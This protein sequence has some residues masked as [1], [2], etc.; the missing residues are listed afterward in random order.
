M[1]SI[2]TAKAL[3]SKTA[4]AG[5]DWFYDFRE[6]PHFLDEDKCKKASAKLSGRYSKITKA[7]DKDRNSEWLCKV[8]LS[9]KMIMTATLQLNT[10]A[11]AQNKNMR[12]VAPYLAY[13]SFLSLLR[14]IVYTLPEVEWDDGQLV[15]ISHSKAIA[16]ACDHLASFDKKLAA[17]IKEKVLEL[18]CKF[19]SNSTP[20]KRSDFLIVAA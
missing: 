2:I 8:Y 5:Q 12:L 10:L 6:L 11:Y 15:K 7:W 13:Y 3:A 20:Q 18:K 4:F 19:R 17:S 14:G 16:L 9:A 1:N